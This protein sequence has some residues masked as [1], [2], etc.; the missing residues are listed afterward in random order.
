[1]AE[2]DASVWVKQMPAGNPVQILPPTR[3]G[4]AS[5]V[6]SNDGNHLYFREENQ[7]GAIYQTPALGGPRKKLTENVWSEFSVSPDGKQ[8][9]FFRRDAGLTQ[10]LL[11]LSNI[12]GSGER[13]VT[14]KSS[15][16]DFRGS[17][18]AW[19]PD[20]T[21]L[22]VV[23]GQRRQFFPK[24]L[25]VDVA[26]GEETEL[27]IPRWRA[28][29]RVLWMP[30]G[31]RLLMTARAGGEQYSQIWML[32]VSDGE[33]RRL[34]NDLES[35]LRISLTADAQMLI[36]RQQRIVSHLWVL[37]EGDLRRA[38]QLTFGERAL[39]S[40]AGLA[41]TPDGKIVFSSFLNNV[42]D[43]YSMNSDGSQRVQLI[44][45]A[46][47][48]NTDPSVA[49][50]SS[51]ILYTSSRTGEAQIWR[52][53]IDGRN[54]RQLT[55]SDENKERA[56]AGTLSPD[57]REVYFIRLGVGPSSIW[58]MPIEGGEAVQVSRLTDATAENF[59]AVSPD[60]KWLAY[61]HQSNRPEPQGD[62][63]RMQIGVIPSDG[64][65]EP[66]IFDLPLRRPMVRWAADSLSFY[67]SSGEFTSSGLWR[68]P[69]DGGPPQ[70]LIDFPDR[71][72]TFAWSP[73]GKHLAVGRGKQ[74]GDAILV[75]NLP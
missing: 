1:L 24:L 69:L 74:L 38:K 60:G 59:V 43:L 18:P 25:L 30:D 72:F 16:W 58:K 53:D 75:T 61:R 17:A 10:D 42:T 46:G 29:F 31:K 21:K 47:Q 33:L 35:Y 32:R 4:Y 12:D 36:T 41:W 5:L 26:T 49:R 52:M 23:S 37:P 45:N 8:L 27:K 3:K 13:Q 66:K 28:I 64:S 51:S 7:A 2:E 14:A 44:M 67:Y 20:G 71:I 50:D 48:D 34:T 57:G 55:F 40:Y 15:P 56:V 39:D 62:E 6:F 9:A 63:D 70:K 54:Q 22:V 68:Q 11:M 73:D 65:G 19:S